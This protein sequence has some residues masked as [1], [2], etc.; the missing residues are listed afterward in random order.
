[1]GVIKTGSEVT[2]SERNKDLVLEMMKDERKIKTRKKQ[3]EYFY[4]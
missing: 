3:P 4:Q 2:E 1:M